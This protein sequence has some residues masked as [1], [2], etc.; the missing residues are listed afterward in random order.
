MVAETGVLASGVGVGEGVGPPAFGSVVGSLA[1]MDD[2]SLSGARPRQDTTPLSSM[3]KT[4][5]I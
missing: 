1:W 2:P 3:P 5:V 4:R